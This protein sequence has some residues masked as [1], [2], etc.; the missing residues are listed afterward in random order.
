PENLLASV[1]NYNDVE[2]TWEQPSGTGGTL[3]Y[4]TG[5]NGYAIGTGSAVDFECAARFTSDELEEFYGGNLTKVN[6]VIASS[7][8]SSV[9]IKVWE[10]GSYG[11]AGVEVY[12]QDITSDVVVGE[13]TEH[14]LSSPIT[15]DSGNEY[16]IGYSISATADHPAAVD[17][18]PMV[19][20][21]G[22]WMYLSGAWGL[23][24][25]LGSGLDYNWC[26]EG[27][28][29]GKDATLSLTQ[30]SYIPVD[31]HSKTDT[32]LEMKVHSINSTSTRALT[33]YKIY[34]NGSEIAELTDPSVLE[35]SDPSLD[36]STYE[37]Y[38]TAIYET[39]E[40]GAS[41]METVEITLPEPAN[42]N[43][44]SQAPTSSNILCTWDA[45]ERNRA[46]TH[47]NVYR[48]G[49]V[50]GTPTNTVYL[51]SE[52]PDGTYE[53]YVTAVYS[54]TYE[55]EPSVVIEV[56]HS[57]SSND[58]PTV[59]AVTELKGNYPNPFNPTTQIKFALAE[60]GKVS[61][62]IFN[63]KGEKVKTLVN[64]NLEATN[65]S[66]VWNG[67][68]DKN[69]QVSSGIYYYRLQID[70]KTEAVKKCILLK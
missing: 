25:N 36:A 34:R 49:E 55:S 18:G 42:F 69:K 54:D 12:T 16:W 6:I 15:L 35:Y 26:V 7:D 52:V 70:G 51:D 43:A 3:S 58:N 45:P 28:V 60:P 50:V 53:Y 65:H 1:N 20:E 21:K 66:V 59:P 32:G 39:D 5:Y 41:N 33:G 46:L 48:D 27:I 11:D 37:Y 22:A 47:Y 44:V 64:G 19:P 17:D 24:P 10:G 67:K 30:S 61:L 9:A 23:L 2:L 4:H 56:E 38:V 8:Y 40:S 31:Y 29:S 62:E 63:V 68:D 14:V 57:T 13:V